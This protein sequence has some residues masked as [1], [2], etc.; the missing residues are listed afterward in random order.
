M[1]IKYSLHYTKKAFQDI[2]S[3]K[4]AKLSAK[5]K[6]LCNLLLLNPAPHNSKQ[7]SGD[8]SGKRSVRIN[9]KHILVYKIF[10]KEKSIKILSMWESL[11]R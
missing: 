8:L 4:A 2:K 1:E 10:E 11:L 9:L 3:L 5:A 7:L 6:K